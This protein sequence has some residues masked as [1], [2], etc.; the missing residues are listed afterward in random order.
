[1]YELEFLV[2]LVDNCF[3][4][5]D[6]M[7]EYLECIKFLWGDIISLFVIYVKLYKV[8]S[9]DIIFWWIKIILGFVGI[10]I[11]CFKFYSIRFLLIS[12]VLIVKVFVVIIFWI[13]GWLGY[14]IFV[15]YYKKLI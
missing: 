11:I 8:V 7:I 2:Y 4:V 13:V 1:M 14:C 12:V 10:D 9:K 15:K 5:V 6:V 3:C